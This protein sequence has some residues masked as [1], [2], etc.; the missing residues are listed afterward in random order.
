MH[1]LGEL[2]AV[3]TV[4]STGVFFGAMLTEGLVPSRTACQ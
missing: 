2:L 4:A 1:L 3:F